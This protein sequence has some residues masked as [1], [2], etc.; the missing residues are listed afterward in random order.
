MPKP[1][2]DLSEF[3]DFPT[4]RRPACR[5][6]AARKGLAPE[7][8]AKLDAALAAPNQRIGASQIV[9]W[10]AT[11]GHGASVTAVTNHRRGGC[12]CAQ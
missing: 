4:T 11:R 2:V 12:S 3:D 5:V 10:L 7:D 9:Q 1:D 8:Q 6:Q